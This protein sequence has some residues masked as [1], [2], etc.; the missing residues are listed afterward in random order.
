MVAQQGV[1]TTRNAFAGNTQNVYGPST[2]QWNG[3]SSNTGRDTIENWNP[4]NWE[5]RDWHQRGNSA[6]PIQYPP[7]T[8][9]PSHG[10][11]YQRTL[12]YVEQCQTAWNPGESKAPQP[13]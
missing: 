9:Q 10:N 4:A 1:S 12:Q 13:N 2:N 5:Y 11:N 6:F 3:A 8:M 7:S